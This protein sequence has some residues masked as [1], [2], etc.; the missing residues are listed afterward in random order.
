MIINL[1][2]HKA[3]PEQ[4]AAGVVDVEDRERISRLLTVPVGGPDGFGAAA[5]WARQARMERTAEAIIDAFVV[6]AVA[7]A[8][9]EY[10]AA[11]ADSDPRTWDDTHAL[12]ARCY[13]PMVKAMVGGF[14]PLMSVLVPMLREHGCEPVV[15]LSDRVTTEQTQ[16]DGSVRKVSAFVHV[17]FHPA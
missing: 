14:P 17:G 8:T 15:A 3:T 7:E 9:R 1:T 5:P 16:P 11:L 4:C 2:Q 12:N 6:P 10:F 13:P